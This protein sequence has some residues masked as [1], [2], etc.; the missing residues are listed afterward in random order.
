MADEHSTDLKQKDLTAADSTARH[1]PINKNVLQSTLAAADK[2]SMNL[3]DNA[4][5]KK[6]IP[7]FLLK[8]E[9]SDSDLRKIFKVACTAYSHLE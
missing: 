9:L 4:V 7:Y 6:M 2:N 1:I 8:F 3:T 5:I